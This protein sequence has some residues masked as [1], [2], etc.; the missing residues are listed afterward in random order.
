MNVPTAE[1]KE[2]GAKAAVA[3]TKP[4]KPPKPKET[5]FSKEMSLG[6]QDL[7]F[8]EIYSIDGYRVKISIRSDSYD[9]QSYA[10]AYVWKKESLE[11]SKVASIHYGQMKTEAKLYYRCPRNGPPAKAMENFFE[12]DRQRLKKEAHFILGIE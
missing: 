6:Q 12:D 4:A 10:H 3:R 5:P 7:I 1:A 9:F 2:I 8:T 11:W